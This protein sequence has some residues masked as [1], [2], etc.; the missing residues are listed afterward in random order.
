M[1]DP[2]EVRQLR[3]CVAMLLAAL[4]LAQEK[5]NAQSA[6]LARLEVAR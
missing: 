2:H 1:Y 6:K 3:D 5:D 4:Q